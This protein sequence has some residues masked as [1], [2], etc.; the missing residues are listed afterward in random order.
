MNELTEEQ[1]RKIITALEHVATMR[2]LQK[3]YFK[4]RLSGDLQRSK[5]YERQVD[6]E[7]AKILADLKAE[8]VEQGRLL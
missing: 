6:I 3:K 2:E 5:Q 1:V 4:D 7:V 8:S